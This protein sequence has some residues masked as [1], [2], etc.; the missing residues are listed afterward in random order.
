MTWLDGL[1]YA[2]DTETTSANPAEARLLSVTLGRSDRPGHWEPRTWWL[3][4]EGFEIPEDSIKVHGI[5]PEVLAAKCDG[6]TR[7]EVLHEVE[8]ELW[9]ASGAPMVGHH[10]RYDLAVIRAEVSREG[11]IYKPPR[12]VLDTLILHR[13]LDRTTG[14]RTLSALAAR[15]GITFPA[16]DSEADALA[17]LRLLHIIANTS[18]LLPHVPLNVLMDLQRDWHRRQQEQAEAKALGNGTPFTPAPGW[19]LPEE[20]P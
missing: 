11:G 5:T 15:H 19:P 18:E 7:R 20:T 1:L 17:S 4:V 3:P 8:Q 2:L 13:Q 10:L 6:R 16:H 14:S 12:Y 9:V